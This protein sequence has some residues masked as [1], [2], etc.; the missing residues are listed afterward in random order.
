[1]RRAPRGSCKLVARSKGK[2]ARARP[3]AGSSGRR[4]GLICTK[5]AFAT[6]D[7]S[8]LP[9]QMSR[10]S[11]LKPNSSMC[12]RRMRLPCALKSKKQY[13][14]ASPRRNSCLWPPSL[15]ITSCRSRARC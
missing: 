13:G 2:R 4:S 3:Y 9:P 8:R 7:A 11:W 6:W 15:A 1:G 5:V 10:I 14:L 12:A